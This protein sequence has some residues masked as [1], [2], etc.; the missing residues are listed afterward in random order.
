[1][2]LS[3]VLCWFCV[4]PLS[5]CWRNAS[6]WKIAV[7]CMQIGCCSRQRGCHGN[8]RVSNAFW[9]E[10]SGVGLDSEMFALSGDLRRLATSS[11]DSDRIVELT[12]MHQMFYYLYLEL[13]KWQSMRPTT[14]TVK[15]TQQELHK[16]SKT[17]A[18]LMSF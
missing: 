15:F 9:A 6:D 4:V 2:F 16:A 11:V 8:A 13:P 18:S 3:I 10:L 14:T 1:M 5:F 12:F 17:F 7:V